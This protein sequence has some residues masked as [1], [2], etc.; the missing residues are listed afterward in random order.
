MSS[1]ANTSLFRLTLF[2][3][4]LSLPSVV[5]PTKV[6]IVP[7]SAKTEFQPLV[8]DVCTFSI[9]HNIGLRSLHVFTIS[10]H[11][12]F[13]FEA[14]KLRRA[15]VYARV[16]DSN[17]S[18]GRRYARNDELGTPFGVTLDFAC[19]WFLGSDMPQLLSKVSRVLYLIYTI[20]LAY[21]L[22]SETKSIT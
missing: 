19:E 17:T 21:S 1:F 11:L 13:P 5:A 3:Q 20:W 7:L 2:I 12:P 10:L 15:G 18:I 8:R 4:V 22:V 6:L 9:S 14:S 16:D